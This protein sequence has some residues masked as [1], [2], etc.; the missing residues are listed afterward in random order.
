MKNKPDSLTASAI[1]P[2]RSCFVQR[3]GVPG[4]TL[5]F[6]GKPLLWFGEVETTIEQKRDTV[7]VTVSRPY[8]IFRQ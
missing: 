4:E 7:T 2:A 8:K 3:P 6:D 5:Y 1:D